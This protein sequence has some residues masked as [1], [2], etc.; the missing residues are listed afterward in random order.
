MAYNFFSDSHLNTGNVGRLCTRPSAVWGTHDTS[1][2]NL[3]HEYTRV[4]PS[5]GDVF[6]FT[7]D[8]SASY[9]R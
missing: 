2:I 8:V 6:R 1:H 7:A 5:F 3:L 9:T 4:V